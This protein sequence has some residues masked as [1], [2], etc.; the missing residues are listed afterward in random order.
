MRTIDIPKE[1]SD[2]QFDAVV[3]AEYKARGYTVEQVQR[4]VDQFADLETSEKSDEGMEDAG[5]KSERPE[6]SEEGEV[7]G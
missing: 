3:H 2:E 7:K 4:L 6:G 5:Q 1:I